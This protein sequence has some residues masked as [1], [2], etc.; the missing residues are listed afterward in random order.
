MDKLLMASQV[1][2]RKLGCAEWDMQF[3]LIL[4]NDH[5]RWEDC[6]IGIISHGR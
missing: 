2:E 6:I 5:S 3:S 1:E 4:R